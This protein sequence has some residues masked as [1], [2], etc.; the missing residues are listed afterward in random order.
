MQSTEPRAAVT[1]P[2]WALDAGQAPYRQVRAHATDRSV[3]VYQAYCPDIAAAAVRAQ[4]FVPPFRM[5]RMTWIKP[6][7]TWMMYR[8]GWA[9]KPDQERIL[10]VE[11]SHEGFLW[12]LA[13]AA[14]AAYDPA[15]HGEHAAWRLRLDEA[16]VRVQWDPE[17]TL[18]LAPLPWRALQVGVGGPAVP[19]FVHDW[20]LGI[21]DVTDMA[22]AVRAAVEAGDRATALALVPP[23][24]PYAVPAVVAATIHASERP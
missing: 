7:F 9:T 8:S 17:R 22:R 11:L 15:L 19:R 12:A 16:P 3:F 20:T 2:T 13:H 6:S 4:R 5:E 23:E 14:E 24:P 18:S 1:S 21:E 10:R